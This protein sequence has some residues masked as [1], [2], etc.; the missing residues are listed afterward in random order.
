MPVITEQSIT[1]YFVYFHPLVFGSVDVSV[2]F[3][4]FLYGH[5]NTPRPR[6]EHR[7][8]TTTTN[9]NQNNPKLAVLLVGGGEE[10]ASAGIPVRVRE[11]DP[12]QEAPTHDPVQLPVPVSLSGGVESPGDP[13]TPLDQQ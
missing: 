10:A 6:H 3:S 13:L 9:A 7:V 11:A 2:G 12:L 5:K 8:P 1:E 4:P